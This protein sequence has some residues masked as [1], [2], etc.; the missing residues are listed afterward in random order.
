MTDDRRVAVA[1]TAVRTHVPPQNA[2]PSGNEAT[3]PEPAGTDQADSD[4]PDTGLLCSVP[5]GAVPRPRP[6][7]SQGQAGSRALIREQLRI[8][9]G[10]GALVLALVIGLPALEALVPAVARARVHG[11]PVP[12]LVLGLGVQPAWIALSFRQLR[13]AERAEREHA[14]RR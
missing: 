9:L 1:G 13:R 7:P 10:T 11:M 5:F 3:G 4:P 12:W 14:G 6:G 8:A 2:S